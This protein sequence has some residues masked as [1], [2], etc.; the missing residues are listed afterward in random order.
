MNKLKYL[1]TI[2]CCIILTIGLNHDRAQSQP[3]KPK[4][5]QSSTL[6]VGRTNPFAK[7]NRPKKSIPQNVSRISEAYE[8]KPDLFLEIITLKFLNA[9]D[10]RLAV[11]GMS[12]EYGS[13]S[14]DAKSNSLIICDTKENLAK[15]I[16]EV[17]KADRTPQ[18]TLFV[19]TTTLKFLEA[20]N[21][22]IA[23]ENMSSQ[24]G[25]ITTNQKTNS[26]IICDTK[27]NLDRILAEI[28]KCDR[29]P[30]QIMVEVVI[31]DVQLK[32]DTEIGI[33][34]D[35]LSDKTYDIGYRQNFTMS[36]LGSTLEDSD[37]IGNATAF[38][39]TGLGGSFSVISGNIRNVIHLIQQK[40]DVEILASPRAMMVSGQSANIQAVEEIPYE[41]VS[42]TAEG[43][44]GALT[45]TEF[46][47]VGINLQV[48]ATI[49][50]DND[51]FL[52]VDTEQNVKTSE[53]VGGVP[54]IDTRRANT[55]LLLSDGQLVVMGGL[56]RQEKTKEVDQIPI[57]GDL[58]IVG[59]LFKSTNI[60]INNS[61]LI[62]LLS[63]H[64]YKG[65][66]ITDQAMVKYN[67]IKN[68]PILSI[69]DEK[70]KKNLAEQVGQ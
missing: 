4:S 19:E 7:I 55:S 41:Q 27:E 20:D 32:D 13:V 59:E 60:V 15:I 6:D 16:E 14:A 28:K 21:L 30:Q 3:P 35:L 42:D 25:T 33:N 70:E 63:P 54:V 31:L 61:E 10:L 65:E 37:T 69:P 26:L 49:T 47:E 57:L 50:D 11:E 36:R 66:P 40:K 68:R 22:K 34:W 18:Q 51:I 62:I 1:K 5:E 44:L 52:T 2:L 38:N 23:L 29:T 8:E 67:E 9:N 46:K 56:R 58:P 48:T 43:G 12:S 64:L 24:Y 45:S 53:S 39:T 17:K